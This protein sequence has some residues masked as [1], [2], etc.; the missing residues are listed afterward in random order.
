MLPMENTG[1]ERRTNRGNQSRSTSFYKQ[2]PF[3][4]TSVM[5]SV[6]LLDNM[7]FGFSSVAE[8]VH[9]FFSFTH[10]LVMKF[11][12]RCFCLKGVSCEGLYLEWHLC[13]APIWDMPWWRWLVVP[14]HCEWILLSSF[15]I[16]PL[17][18]PCIN[19]S[20]LVQE[21]RCSKL[22]WWRSIP[23]F[24]LSSSVLAPTSYSFFCYFCNSAALMI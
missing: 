8:I 9:L 1:G 4:L 22:A 21:L 16:F 3:Q 15:N 14:L 23:C 2:H 12:K 11:W 7:R 19:R 6:P 13:E 17:L 24:L 5:I 20:L 18:I 10:T